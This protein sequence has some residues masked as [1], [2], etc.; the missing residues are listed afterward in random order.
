MPSLE[1]AAPV[2]GTASA[3]GCGQLFWMFTQITMLG[4]GGVLPW[5]YRVL[6]D[7]R[8]ILSAAEFRELFALGQVLPGPSICNMA[9]MVGYR[10][11]GVAGGASALA[12]MM[13]G[14]MV[15]M[16]VLGLGYEAHGR[17]PMLASVLAGMSAVAA[18]LIVV[19]ALRMAVALPRRWRNML[20]AALALA[21]IAVAHLALW[22]VLAGLAPIGMLLLRRD[23]PE[24]GH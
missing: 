17:S 8:R 14:P 13:L 10:H 3:L 12:G 9:V 20:M 16:I 22:L 24:T 18:G 6:V 23:R 15:L 2:A 21:G 19:M 1:P 5:M 4:F 7:Q 11:A